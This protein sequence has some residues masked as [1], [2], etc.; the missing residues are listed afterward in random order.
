MFTQFQELMNKMFKNTYPLCGNNLMFCVVLIFHLLVKW[1]SYNAFGTAKAHS[2][3]E[4]L[5]T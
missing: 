2:V 1:L 4:L 3:S 5:D